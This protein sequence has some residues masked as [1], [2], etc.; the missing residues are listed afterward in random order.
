MLSVRGVAG[1]ARGGARCGTISRV[2]EWPPSRCSERLLCRRYAAMG[3]GQSAKTGDVTPKMPI[4][5][6]PPSPDVRQTPR[7]LSQVGEPLS[8]SVRGGVAADTAGHEGKLWRSEAR[9]PIVVVLLRGAALRGT[10][11]MNEQH[12]AF[13]SVH[14]HVVKAAYSAFNSTPCVAVD[15]Q[16]PGGGL[17]VL[18]AA[19]NTSVQ[20]VFVDSRCGRLQGPLFRG[21]PASDPAYVEPGTH[22]NSQIQTIL[23]SMRWVIQS[24]LVHH[25]P[26]GASAPALV[27][28]AP[29]VLKHTHWLIVRPDMRFQMALRLPRHPDWDQAVWSLWA[30][31]PWLGRTPKRRDR[32]NDLLFFVPNRMTR[33]FVRALCEH[34]R[35]KSLHDFGDWM[36]PR[37]VRVL[38]PEK[39]MDADSGKQPNPLYDLIGRPAISSDDPRVNTLRFYNCRSDRRCTDA[40]LAARTA[41]APTF[42][43]II[44]KNVPCG[45]SPFI[46]AGHQD[47]ES[48]RPSSHLL[49][50]MCTAPQACGTINGNPNVSSIC[51]QL[52]RPMA[53][54][55]SDSGV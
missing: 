10:A 5:S 35:S 36:E 20:R 1:A 51:E 15:A 39:H 18:T 16:L 45:C 7:S 42:W 34:D 6:T 31:W 19:V 33:P 23:G 38:Y 41:Q 14:F 3:A 2:A 25:H 43:G 29:D 12:N 55:C 37:Q 4:E 48:S 49:Y 26:H 24:L 52:C 53:R 28:T 17:D 50:K 46:F 47:D 27:R 40:E 13:L 11:T 44:D 30:I 54:M 9:H 32:L 22:A 21:A 8:S